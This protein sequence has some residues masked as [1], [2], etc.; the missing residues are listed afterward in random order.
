MLNKTKI[1]ATIGPSSNNPHIIKNMIK[2]GMNIARL[3]MAHNS[4]NKSVENIVR[5]I[6]EESNKLN[7]FVAI[8][9]DIAGPKV[10][11][12]FSDVK[13]E[14]LKITKNKI[15]TLGYL[16]SNDIK[17]NMD[18]NFKSIQDKQAF[19]KIDDGKIVFKIL[20]ISKNVLKIKSL[21]AG[22][23][24]LNKGI[25]FPGIALD[26]PTL[27]PKDIK[28]IKLGIKL[29]IDWF[30]LSFVRSYKDLDSF[31]QFYSNNINIPVIAKIEKPEAIDDLDKII[32]IFDGILIA[33][34][35]LGVEMPLS[36]L[37]VLQKNIIK[38]CRLEKKPIIIATQI[39]ESMIQHSS[40]TRAEVNDVANAVYEEVDAVMLS[41]ETA[42][43]AF[44]LET[45]KIMKEII[46]NIEKEI[47]ED[48]KITSKFEE[49]SPRY[50]IG[51]AVK[52]ITKNLKV[53][54]I[55]VMTESGETSRIVSHFR[56]RA[57]IFSLSPYLSI[58]YRN[59]LLW[60]VISIQT[61]KYSSTDEM[62]I[63]AEKLLLNSKYIKS[64]Q[65]FVMTAGIP[66]GVSGSTNM[67]KIHK[68]ID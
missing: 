26:V 41:G 64:G 51:E 9:M 31:K 44:P 57:N 39:L 47:I 45:I 27:T 6:R 18:I 60:G 13:D 12:D 54:A 40:P 15:Y 59:S 28:H 2:K 53:K 1:I 32:K 14:K 24:T 23:V 37:P 55:V 10:R 42:V 63:N 5:I 49:H 33:R 62:L 68:I 65:T 35:D 20:S 22:I 4:S 48:F 46:L 8:L 16:K 43:G 7:Q 11:V 21:N 52:S 36:K 17:I 29:K 19:V 50:A 34:G 67:L 38:K 61:E 58:C 3:N 25:N 56:P 30:A 66:V